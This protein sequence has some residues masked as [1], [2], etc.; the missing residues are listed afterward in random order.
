MNAQTSS[1]QWSE[2]CRPRL[3]NTGSS[4]GQ[5]LTAP[6]RTPA[7]LTPLGVPGPAAA[8]PPLPGQAGGPQARRG[9]G[10]GALRSRG[11]CGSPGSWARARRCSR[12]CARP[13]GHGR[14]AVTMARPEA[15]SPG[16][17]GRFEQEISSGI[18]AG[19]LPVVFLPLG[20][21]WELKQSPVCALPEALSSPMH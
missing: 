16:E 10:P 11:G 3:R 1:K 21:I 17:G 2:S 14:R 18:Q 8:S 13:R 4:R 6:V 7:L 15:L 9:P 20:T 19:S 5:S 12:R